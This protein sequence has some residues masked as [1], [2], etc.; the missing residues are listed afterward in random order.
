MSRFQIIDRETNMHLGFFFTLAEAK[1]RKALL[2][3]GK[4]GE[5]DAPKHSPR[6]FLEKI[7]FKNL[8][9]DAVDEAAHAIFRAYFHKRF[10][11]YQ[12]GNFKEVQ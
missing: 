7:G 5:M 3:V 9:G 4:I 8:S 6:H 1:Q 10:K 12:T 11:I 2:T